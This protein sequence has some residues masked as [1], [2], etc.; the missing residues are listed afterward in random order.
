MPD[1]VA[2]LSRRPFHRYPRRAR[3]G[4]AAAWGAACLVAGCAQAPVAPAAR[5]APADRVERFAD[6]YMQLLPVGQVMASAAAQDARWPLGDKADLVSDAQLA[7]MRQALSP[8]TVASR[9]RQ[10]ARDYARAH[11]DSLDDD[12]R[13]LEGGAARLIGQAMMAG[14]ERTPAAALA[15][16]TA[17]P[18][19]T[20]A[21]AAFATE[22]RYAD[23]R[24]ATGRDA[25][26]GGGT[27][28]A[29]RGG[30]EL[31]QALLVRHMT[32]AFLTCHIPVKLL[33]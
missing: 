25:L 11:P 12:L 20:Q 5:V 7:C 18:E 29:Q 2:R 32:E 17:T 26:I 4:A 1:G 15:G 33:Y 3:F 8:Q 19:Q 22:P 16:A 21:L 23:L 6:A 10:S 27:Q 30:R 31:G 24:R 13:V 28:R 14:A 9:Q